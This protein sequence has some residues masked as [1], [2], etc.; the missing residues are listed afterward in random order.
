[1]QETWDSYADTAVDII[2]NEQRER[3]LL[4]SSITTGASLVN[5]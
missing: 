2:F 4:K 5:V 3:S 1:M